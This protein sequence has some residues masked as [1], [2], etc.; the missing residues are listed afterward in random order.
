MPA[1]LDVARSDGR[2]GIGAGLDHE[3]KR[4]VGLLDRDQAVGEIGLEALVFLPAAEVEAGMVLHDS[5]PENTPLTVS[6]PNGPASKLAG[7]GVVGQRRAH[8]R[9]GR[10]RRRGRAP[11]RRRAAA[12]RA[13][14]AVVG[15][16]SASPGHAQGRRASAHDQLQILHWIDPLMIWPPT[17][18]RVGG[19]AGIRPFRRLAM[20]GRRRPPTAEPWR[21]AAQRRIGH[22]LCAAASDCPLFR[23]PCAQAWAS[24]ERHYGPRP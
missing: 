10:R 2:E 22:F 23:R 16:G 7:A 24:S 12:S 5:R 14:P 13:A 11:E 18:P 15:E 6:L 4:T 21:A 8:R 3:L 20:V 9:I 1:G 19:S 17:I